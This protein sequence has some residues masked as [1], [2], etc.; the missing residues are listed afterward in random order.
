MLPQADNSWHIIPFE[1]CKTQRKLPS[2]FSPTISQ[3]FC[4]GCKYTWLCHSSSTSVQIMP[5]SVTFKVLSTPVPDP[6][7]NLP[8][9]LVNTTQYDAT[10]TGKLFYPSHWTTRNNWHSWRVKARPY[11]WN[12]L[13]MKLADVPQD[14]ASFENHMS[15]S[16]VTESVCKSHYAFLYVPCAQTKHKSTESGWR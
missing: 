1:K 5:P 8:P 11:G 15:K 14:C 9:H 12:Y 7:V 3:C 2:K 6:K 10:D 16:V 4:R 13:Q